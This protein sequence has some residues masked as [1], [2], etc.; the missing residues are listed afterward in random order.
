MNRGPRPEAVI[1]AV[2]F[3]GT[4]LGGILGLILAIPLTAFLASLW[5]LARE[6]YI[7]EIV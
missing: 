1:V 3:R 7:P 2:F 5:R 6:K 4:A